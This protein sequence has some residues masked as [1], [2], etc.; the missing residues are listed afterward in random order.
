MIDTEKKKLEGFLSKAL[1][2]DSEAMAGL[3]NEAGELTDLT[4]AEEADALRIKKLKE[5]AS[6]Q[7]KRGLKEG[8]I[9]IETELKDKY[10]VESDKIGVEL[11]D[12]IV[13]EKVSAAKPGSDDITKHPDYKSHTDKLI[14]LK[15]KEWQG[16]IDAMNSEFSK[17]AIQ[18]K[19]R[20]K[21]LANL[22]EYRPIIAGDA[23]KVLRWKEKYIEELYKSEYQDHDGTPVPI[24]DGKP[25]QDEHGN[26][27]SFDDFTKN[28]ATEL[29]D[30]ETAEQR[31]S[32][33]NTT[34]GHSGQNFVVP[35]NNE[36]YV[37]E[38]KKLSAETPENKKKRIELMESY[39]KSK[40]Q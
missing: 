39:T 28:V 26:P 20:E 30:F 23:K 32:S 15:E 33:G 1:K 31:S 37:A 8:A 6:S 17:K 3:Y 16:K 40:K 4:A 7:Y 36:E 29:F 35:K 38:M 10:E 27:I 22:D 9:K 14:K 34:F 25:I 12:H 11:I 13:S 19:V 24:K 21:G 18:A 2:L 5:D